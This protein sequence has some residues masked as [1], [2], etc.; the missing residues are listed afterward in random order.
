[1][2]IGY[3]LSGTILSVGDRYVIKAVIG[4]AQLGLYS[5]AYNAASTSATP[6]FTRSARR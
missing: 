6:S 5:A 4:D 2:M 1:M 3:E